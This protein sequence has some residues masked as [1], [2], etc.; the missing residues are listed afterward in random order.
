[1]VPPFV[2]LVS[3][4]VEINPRLYRGKKKER[5]Y[6]KEGELY[7]AQLTLK[8]CLKLS[9]NIGRNLVTRSRVAVRVMR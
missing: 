9:H 7:A 5:S 6:K 3:L 4:E 8:P 1:M 2:C